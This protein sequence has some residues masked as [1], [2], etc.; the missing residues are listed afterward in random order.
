[1]EAR[2]RSWLHEREYEK[3]FGGNRFQHGVA[4]EVDG[5]MD[6]SKADGV[7]SR[8]RTG[9]R[10]HHREVRQ[11]ARADE[12]DR[13]VQHF[14]IDDCAKSN[15]IVDKNDIISSGRDQ[16]EVMF[17]SIWQSF[18]SMRDSCCAETH[19]HRRLHRG[20]QVRQMEIKTSEE[21]GENTMA[22]SQSEHDRRSGLAKA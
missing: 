6:L 20:G 11:R 16:N 13:V 12:F 15:E 17:I 2:W 4:E 10:V 9:V 21:I 18:A 14:A 22:S 1:M 8:D 5:C 7:A 3:E 19:D